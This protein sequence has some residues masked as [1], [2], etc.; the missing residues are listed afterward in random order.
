MAAE[1]LGDPQHRHL[2]FAQLENQLPLSQGEV[3]AACSQGPDPIAQQPAETLGRLHLEME[4]T[5]LHGYP[6]QYILPGNWRL[7]RL[8]CHALGAG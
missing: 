4:S 1:P 2:R 8:V 6:A 3:V 5:R 7:K